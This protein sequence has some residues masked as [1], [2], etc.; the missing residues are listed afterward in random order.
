[1]TDPGNDWFREVVARRRGRPVEEPEAQAP[2]DDTER[3]LETDQ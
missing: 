2:E 3:E 1:M